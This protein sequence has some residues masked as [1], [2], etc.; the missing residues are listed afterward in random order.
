MKYLA[1]WRFAAIAAAAWISPS[2]G[3]AQTA[4]GVV[5]IQATQPNGD[6]E[7]CADAE[8]SSGPVAKA[9]VA[10]LR[11]SKITIAGLFDQVNASVAAANKG[12]QV[13]WIAASGPID[14]PLTENPAHSFA[15]VIG[16]G[17]YTRLPVLKGAP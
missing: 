9:I 14:V 12:R 8:C 4:A 5:V 16:N 3:Q 7:D 15:L 2:L 11:S 1:D 17:A 10:A 13:P 6:A